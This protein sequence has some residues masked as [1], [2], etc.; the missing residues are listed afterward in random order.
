MKDA[1][2]PALLARLREHA[3]GCQFAHASEV[4]KDIEG[5]KVRMRAAGIA[6]PL[7]ISRD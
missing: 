7:A 5:V 1:Q 4:F 6:I 2:L 3:K